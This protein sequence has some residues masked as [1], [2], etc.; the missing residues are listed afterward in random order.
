VIDIH[1]HILPGIDDGPEDPDESVEMARIA[2]L[3]G[4][5][6]IV[7]TPHIKDM[8]HPASSI[9]KKIAVLNAQLTEKNIPVQ[10]FRGA[11]VS[12]M[13]DVSLLQCYTINGTQYILI[14]FPHTHLP[15]N[16][17]EILFRLMMNGFHPIITHPERNLSVLTNPKLLFELLHTGISVQI[18]AGSLTGDF[19]VDIQECALYLIKKG[20]VSFIATDAHSSSERRPVLSEG[21]K[22]A[23]RIIG[24]EKAL[25][26]VTVNPER[27]LQGRPVGD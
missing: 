7:A 18:T 21:V 20:V 9:E 26:M 11:D 19:G 17:G 2:S 3:D 5:T 15:R 12:A 22:A 25:H 1:C 4:I 24:K 23:E 16:S 10:I 14:E 13:L 6:K 27:V 8:R